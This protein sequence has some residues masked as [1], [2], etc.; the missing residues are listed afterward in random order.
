MLPTPRLLGRLP[1]SKSRGRPFASYSDGD[2]VGS[3]CDV[4]VRGDFGG[5][6]VL[7]S[8]EPV[9]RRFGG[10]LER[11]PEETVRQGEAYAAGVQ[12]IG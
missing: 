8:C 12:D 10:P 11:E 6:I 2:V 9:A 5:N 1:R 3:S 4:I 7:E